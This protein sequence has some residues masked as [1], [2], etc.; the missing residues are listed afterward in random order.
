LI[1]RHS[2]IAP[3]RLNPLCSR[4][5]DEGSTVIFVQI[6]AGDILA[7]ESRVLC[8]ASFRKPKRAAPPRSFP[9]VVSPPPFLFVV[10]TPAGGVFFGVV[11]GETIWSSSLFRRRREVN[12]P[13]LPPLF[14]SFTLSFSA[15]QLR[16]RRTARF[17]GGG[18]DYSTSPRPVFANGIALAPLHPRVLFSR[19]PP[20]PF[21]LATP[22]AS[23]TP[24]RTS[25]FVAPLLTPFLTLFRGSPL[26]PP[27]F[28]YGMGPFLRCDPRS[29][30]H[31]RVVRNPLH[32]IG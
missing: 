7:L 23:T 12:L 19:C 14:H 25:V 29:P 31:E 13:P 21:L 8:R 1:N 28:V 26:F 3:S 5:T 10:D 2:K 4:I 27:A 20:I 15:R 22:T 18:G 16:T 6:S 24:P 17:S 11:R 9:F 32:N 30:C